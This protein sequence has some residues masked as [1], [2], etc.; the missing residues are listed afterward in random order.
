MQNTVVIRW[1]FHG[2]PEYI[3]SCKKCLSLLNNPAIIMK[4]K[5][6]FALIVVIMVSF[7]QCKKEPDNVSIPNDNFLQALIEEGIDTN[8]DGIISYQEAA[9]VN[10]LNV[11]DRDLSDIKGIES[12]V[13]LEYLYCENNSLT[14]LEISNNLKLM[15]LR[16][17]DNPLK[18]LVLS[19]N[20]KLRELMCNNTSIAQLDISHNP[21]LVYLNCANAQLTRLDI[22]NNPNL[23][24]MNCGQN[25]LTV[26]DLS[27]Q[28][29]LVSLGCANNHLTSLNLSHNPGLQFLWCLSNS[30]SEL[31]LSNNA[32]LYLLS[33]GANSLTSL[34]ISNNIAL[35]HL[36][37]M[38]IPSLSKVC[39]WSL[40]IPSEVKIDTTGSPN[41]YF[42]ANC[43]E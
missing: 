43:S 7:C 33:C 27:H 3:N 38:S 9:A 21:E 39:V 12:F 42:T 13:N 16:C 29:E 6:K 10:S 22:S 8:G 23:G 17:N 26:L 41:V 4:T 1:I 24:D 30:L 32:E 35:K 2:I 34:D 37:F 36:A 11:K 20:Q 15:V 25:S 31:D 28:S 18:S 14:R 19:N 40:P 5:V